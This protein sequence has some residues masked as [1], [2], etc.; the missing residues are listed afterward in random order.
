MPL[1][2]RLSRFAVCT[3]FSA[4]AVLGGTTA[5]TA[6]PPPPP[7]DDP[8]RC[9]RDSGDCRAY[10][11]SNV[12]VDNDFTGTYDVHVIDDWHGVRPGG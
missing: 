7:D 9:A 10:G 2:Q 4:A 8:R 12:V 1:S 3:A 6:V 11:H 5:A